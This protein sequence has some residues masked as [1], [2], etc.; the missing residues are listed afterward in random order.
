M[1]DDREILSW[2]IGESKLLILDKFS[3]EVFIKILRFPMMSV[4]KHTKSDKGFK[5]HLFILSCSTK[6]STA[7]SSYEVSIKNFM[8]AVNNMT[9]EELLGG[10]EQLKSSL[11]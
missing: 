6:A 1:F 2:S 10:L 5:E 9:D 8:T 4:R 7:R 11:K 3:N